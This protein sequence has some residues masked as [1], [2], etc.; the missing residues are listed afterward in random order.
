MTVSGSATFGPGYLNFDD[1][2]YVTVPTNA[3]LSVNTWVWGAAEW[4]I[5]GTL[6]GSGN[7]LLPVA[8]NGGTI[9]GSVSVG[10]LDSSGGTLTGTPSL[11]TVNVNSGSLSVNGTVNGD[12]AFYI[13]SGGTLTGL[14]GGQL[15]SDIFLY[16]GGAIT[17]TF[18]IT[19]DGWE[20]GFVMSGGSISGTHVVD[21]TASGMGI[22]VYGG[23]VTGANTF[24]ANSA[25][26]MVVGGGAFS[27]TTTVN[28]S[29][30]I[31]PV[32]ND[33]VT[34]RSR[35]PVPSAWPE[36]P[37]YTAALSWRITPPTPPP[38]TPP[39]FSSAAT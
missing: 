39:G 1:T 37:S 10:T 12:D 11:G 20:S 8:I 9:G 35:P 19:T 24:N 4:Q 18:N 26:G 38:A 33:G 6:Q 14:G 13:N 22:V 5:G 3:T 28:G 17:G 36:P 34:S 32:R 15:T 23:T 21:D 31:N 30:Y 29:L 25:I 2:Y 16:A 27:G 7:I